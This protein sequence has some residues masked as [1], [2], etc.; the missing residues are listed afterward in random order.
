MER[1]IVNHV[2]LIRIG[3]N[4]NLALDLGTLAEGPHR[5]R[6]AGVLAKAHYDKLAAMME[7]LAELEFVFSTDKN[8]LYGKSETVGAR[9][10]KEYLLAKGFQDQDFQIHLEYSRGWGMM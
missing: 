1:P 8:Y 10:S 7:A 4:A 2:T 5:L 6:E 3:L 9:E